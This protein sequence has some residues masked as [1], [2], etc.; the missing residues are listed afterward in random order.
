MR[1]VVQGAEYEQ[2][3]FTPEQYESL[4]RLTAALCQTFPA[5]RGEAPRGADGAVLQRVL[6]D[7]E[8]RAFQG[9]LGHLHVQVNKI[10]PG[11]AFDW[12]RF[13]ARV[14]ERMTERAALAP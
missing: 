13:L 11:P 9:I 4:A 6:D 14:R 3:D 12:E 2:H 7:E 5:L 10:D 8:W 1:G